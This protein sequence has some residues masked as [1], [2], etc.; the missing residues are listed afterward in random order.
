VLRL[1][2]LAPDVVEAILD[3]R[4]SEGLTLPGLMAGVEVEWSGRRGDSS[5]ERCTIKS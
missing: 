1:T 2:L 4:Q 3:G 5:R